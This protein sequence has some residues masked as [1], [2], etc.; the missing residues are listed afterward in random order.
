MFLTSHGIIRQIKYINKYFLF[1]DIHGRNLDEHKAR[2]KESSLNEDD[3][4]H[5]LVSLGDLFDRGN[6]SYNLCKYINSM[7]NKN[8]C[9]AL[10]GNMK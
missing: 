7:I 2:S 3:P 1:S 5:I 4:N 6:D 8:K 9:I 10:W